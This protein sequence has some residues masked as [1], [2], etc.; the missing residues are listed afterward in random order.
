MAT[1]WQ[2][3]GPFFDRKL[4]RHG[5]DLTRAGQGRPQ[6]EVIELAGRVLQDGGAPVGGALIEIW[7]AN[8]AG[9]Y[10]H[11]ADC[12]ARPLD[13]NFKGFGRT[14]TDPE[15]RYRFVTVKPGAVPFEGNRWQAPHILVAIFAAGLL[16]RLVTRL[17]FPDEPA[18]ESDPILATV[19]DPMARA[20]LI[21]KADG[22][23]SY[24]FDIV[25]RGAGE[26]AFFVD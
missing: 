14:L 20:T 11:P 19:G 18:N 23:G 5:H 22:A 1:A 7:Q 6:G 24:R 12:S 21:A 4:I 15:G 9:R 17:Y 16:R 10:A 2:T 13:P 8:S 26:T 3:L 25:L